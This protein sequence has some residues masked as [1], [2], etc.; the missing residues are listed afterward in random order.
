MKKMNIAQ[1][2]AIAASKY[3]KLKEERIEPVKDVLF[4]DLT[5]SAAERK[6]KVCTGTIQRDVNR[7][8]EFFAVCL[9]VAAKQTKA[10]PKAKAK[11]K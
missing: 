4:N 5:A 1:F 3:I 6:H 7:I 2:T 10:K 8:N 9:E 11:V